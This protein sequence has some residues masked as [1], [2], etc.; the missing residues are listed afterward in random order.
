MPNFPVR[1][2][3]HHDIP[4]WVESG[5]LYFVTINCKA[6]G[7]NSLCIDERSKRLF[8]TV[9]HYNNIHNWHCILFLLMPD[10]LH[11]LVS[12]P[13][14]QSMVSVLKSWKRYTA[15]KL[16][17]AWQSGF[18]DHRIRNDECWEEKAHYIRSNPVRKSLVSMDREW[19]FVW[20]QND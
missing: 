9:E 13:S 3:L 7:P 19:P 5:S 18:F 16:G 14:E 1:K 2:R 12:F 11:A 17:I 15:K 8:K 10:H 20:P 6:K 4:L